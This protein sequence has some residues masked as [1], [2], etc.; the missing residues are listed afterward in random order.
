[1]SHR[2]NDLGIV[3]PFFVKLCFTLPVNE[4]ALDGQFVLS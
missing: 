1:M 3:A 2:F 4:K